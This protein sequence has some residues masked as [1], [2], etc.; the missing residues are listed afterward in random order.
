MNHDIIEPELELV[1]EAQGKLA[2]PMII[3]ETYE[4]VHRIIPI[5]E[6][7]FEGPDIRGTIVSTGAADWQFTRNDK[8]TQAE[9]TYALR[10][11]DD[12]LIQVQ[13]YGLRHGPD[14]VMERLAAGQEVDPAEYY[15]RTSPR[16]TA[17]S[18]KYDWLNKSIFLCSGA[19]YP[20][21]IRLMFYRVL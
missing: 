16:F 8:V 20:H 18:G 13:N 6:G 12:V 1:F 19:R 15:F 21:G 2:A 10:T 17:P 14:A 9:A 5:L 11:D 7:S 4:G 3:G